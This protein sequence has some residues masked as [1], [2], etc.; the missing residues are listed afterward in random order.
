MN[1][2]AKVPADRFLDLAISALA[3]TDT[4]AI[5]T[6]AN[7]VSTVTKPISMADYLQNR[8]IYAALLEETG[9]NLRLLLRAAEQRRANF[10][11]SGAR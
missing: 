2:L 5:T 3:S 4:S 6:L 11:I 10:Y 8:D 1:A 7:G 9:R